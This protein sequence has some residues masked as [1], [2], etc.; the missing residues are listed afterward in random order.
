VGG[1]QPAT[2]GAVNP[3]QLQVNPP[4]QRQFVNEYNNMYQELQDRRNQEG[5][6]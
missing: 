2:L 1:Y 3:N 6:L 5:E 4:L